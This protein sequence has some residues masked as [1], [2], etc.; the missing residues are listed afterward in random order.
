MKFACPHCTGHLEADAD[1]A[2]MQF[3][4]PHCQ[5]LLVVPGEP[6]GAAVPP[7]ASSTS[8]KPRKRASTVRKPLVIAGCG[9]GGIVAVL[10][11]LI[12]LKTPARRGEDRGAVA[13]L[14]SLVGS[15]G[16]SPPS[17]EQ[18][19][20]LIPGKWKAVDGNSDELNFRPDGRFKATF[21]V[22]GSVG[23][24]VPITSKGSWLALEDGKFTFM[25]GGEQT[26]GQCS[27]DRIVLEKTPG[28]SLTFVKTEGPEAMVAAA[29]VVER[30]KEELGK[31]MA[32][33]AKAIKAYQRDHGGDLGKHWSEQAPL[34][35]DDPYALRDTKPWE[36]TYMNE[37][38]PGYCKQGT[39]KDVYGPVFGKLL[40]LLSDNHKNLTAEEVSE[41]RLAH[42]TLNL[43]AG[44]DGW[45]S[46]SGDD[47]RC[48]AILTG[49]VEDKG[50]DT[51]ETVTLIVE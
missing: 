41:I 51:Y 8:H 48:V 19:K 14:L 26:P 24:L 36:G 37:G 28:S 45:V 35:N 49:A 15:L 13:S 18:L 6:A 12:L 7:E 17:Q 33:A 9:F 32:K 31:T 1:M 39:D 50:M 23:N 47:H 16:S 46:D 25:E 5:S 11:I 34:Y 38:G 42:L 10:A 22:P 30:Q 27:G 43:D 4:C 40:E 20:T 44:K 21:Y 3:A 29:V 2:G